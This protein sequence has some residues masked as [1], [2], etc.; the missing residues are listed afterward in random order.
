MQDPSVGE[1]PTRGNTRTNDM[2][3]DLKCPKCY[4]TYRGE[5]FNGVCTEDCFK[6]KIK[7]ILVEKE[8]PFLPKVDRPLLTEEQMRIKKINEKWIERE[9][10]NRK[11]QDSS[12]LERKRAWYEGDG[13]WT[14]RFQHVRG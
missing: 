7:A 6:K 13:K 8:N 4:R 11:P 14:K 10:V 3:R 1:S 9:P 12:K 2:N 5:G